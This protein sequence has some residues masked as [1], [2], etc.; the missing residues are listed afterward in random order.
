MG[1]AKDV[2]CC[3]V[4]LQYETYPSECEQSAR[5]VLLIG[6]VEIRD[7]LADSH[8][9]KLLYHYT[10]EAMPKQSHAS[11]VSTG[12]VVSTGTRLCCVV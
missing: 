11:M 5:L 9:N 12:G 4:R 2:Q 8:I 10:T 6:D 7:R 1:G 3:Q